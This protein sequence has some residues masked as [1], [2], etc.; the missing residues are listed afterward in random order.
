M[1]TSE[2]KPSENCQQE[3]LNEMRWNKGP[4]TPLCWSVFVS[5]LQSFYAFTTPP[6][7]LYTC[8][9]T[10]VWHSC[11]PPSR[12]WTSTAQPKTPYRPSRLTSDACP[13][14][15]L[16][17]MDSWDL[18]PSRVMPLLLHMYISLFFV[19]YMFCLFQKNFYK[20]TQKTLSDH[21]QKLLDIDG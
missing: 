13:P 15:V 3:L 18:S 9:W 19:I 21:I 6:Q 11:L 20:F 5:Q 16:P 4:V 1:A 10:A 2:D 7:C 12:T 8:A 17:V 14:P